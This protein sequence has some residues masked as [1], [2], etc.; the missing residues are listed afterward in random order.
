LISVNTGK[1][2][3]DT[4]AWNTSYFRRRLMEMGFIVYGNEHS[5]VIPILLFMP[6][7]IR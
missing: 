2:R 7:K 5:P 1:K 3:I 4:L 6:G